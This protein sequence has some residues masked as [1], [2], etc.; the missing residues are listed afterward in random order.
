LSAVP[1]DCDSMIDSP[2]IAAW[3]A[4]AGFW[5]LMALAWASGEVRLKGTVTFLG[6]WVAGFIGL[7]HLPYGAA[8]FPPFVALLDITLVL[9]IFKGDIRLT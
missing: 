2:G 5:M 3:I 7:A 1:V 6:L 9:V 4:Q 8:L